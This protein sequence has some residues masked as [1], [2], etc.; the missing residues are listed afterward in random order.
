M[1]IFAALLSAIFSTS[2]DVLSKKL[3]VRIDGTASTF[4]SFAFA[5]PF[6][7][8]VLAGL[9]LLGHD[10]FTFSL[11]FWW[12]VLARALTDTFAEGMKMYAF[13]HGD[14]SLVSILFSASP[15]L[16]LALSPLLTSDEPSL[17]GALAVVLVVAGSMAVVYNPGAY[18][19]DSHDWASQ[20]KAML[21]AVGA[22]FFFALNSIL[23]RLAVTQN[24]SDPAT[25]VV[26]GF[27]MTAVSATMLL[28]A[29][30]LRPERLVGLYAWRRGLAARG[31]LEVAFMV[32]KL[33]AM[34]W[35][36]A[37]YVVGLQR[38]SLVLSIIAG[39]VFFK[40]G[41]FKRRMIAGGLIMAGVAWIV[42]ERVKEG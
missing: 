42:W 8:I 7:L 25:A 24:T 17:S 30:L 3:A 18:A 34:Q 40:E 9:W 37:A 13:S 4:A 38:S 15:L 41:D 27:T 2:K 12:L 35:L 1:G 22:S 5:I 23:D 32:C 6:Y 39:R 21:L 28:P 14:I 19:A 16:V 36:E 10:I 33:V 31:F 29:V 11:T 26:A 20:K